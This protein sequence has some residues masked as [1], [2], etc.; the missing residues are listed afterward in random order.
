M[1]KSKNRFTPKLQLLIEFDAHFWDV[2]HVLLADE[3]DRLFLRDEEGFIT[4]TTVKAALEWF[5]RSSPYAQSWHGGDTFSIERL[6][7]IAANSIPG[8]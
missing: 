5:A 1:S 4:P 7:Q 6:F 3:K 8:N 2:P